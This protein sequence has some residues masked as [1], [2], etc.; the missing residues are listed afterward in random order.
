MFDETHRELQASI[1]K[2]MFELEYW[3]ETEEILFLA[4][5][6]CGDKKSEL[7]GT[8]AGAVVICPWSSDVTLRRMNVAPDIF[9]AL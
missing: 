5:N 2:V 9:N 1:I 8:L 6:E 3:P 4:G 7:W